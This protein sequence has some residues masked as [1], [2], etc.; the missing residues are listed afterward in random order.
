MGRREVLELVDQKHPGTPPGGGAGRRVRQEHL[1]G[2]VDLL[3]EV[4]GGGDRPTAPGGRLEPLG[5]PRGVGER[6]RRRLGRHQTQPDRRRAST[7]GATTSVLARRRTSKVRSTS[8][9]TAG[10]WSTS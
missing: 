1:D 4:E 8:S 7:Y 3:V 2:P 6:R 5:H 9:R 10:S